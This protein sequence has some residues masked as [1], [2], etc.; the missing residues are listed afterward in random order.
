LTKTLATYNQAVGGIQLTASV[1]VVATSMKG[2]LEKSYNRYTI[3]FVAFN[4]NL[5]NEL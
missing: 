2:F 4:I 3:R 1:V 5:I